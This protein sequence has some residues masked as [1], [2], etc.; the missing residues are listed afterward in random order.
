MRLLGSLLAST[1]A[2]GLAAGC[3]KNVGTPGDK[4]AGKTAAAAMSTPT[5][6]SAPAGNPPMGKFS[7]SPMLLAWTLP[8]GWKTVP[9]R[10]RMRRAEFELPAAEGAAPG[11]VAVFHF[12]GTGG[13]RMANVQRWIGQFKPAAG[14]DAKPEMEDRSTNGLK[15]TTVFYKGTYLKP[16]NPMAMRGPKKEFANW[17]LLAAIVQTPAGP[18]FFKGTGPEK[19]MTAQRKAFGEFVATIKLAGQKTAEPKSPQPKAE[20]KKTA[21]PRKTAEPKK[22]GAK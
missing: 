19:T 3:S 7:A 10:S 6:S 22:A 11:R 20:P 15:I 1:L 9:P 21:E 12:P 8:A 2:F 14:S 5:K 18:W 13:Q 4:P 17:A 16:Q